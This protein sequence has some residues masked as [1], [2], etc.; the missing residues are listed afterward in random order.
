M[1]IKYLPNPAMFL[2]D[3][4]LLFEINRRVLH[5]F[6]IALA[7]ECPVSDEEKALA[8]KSDH[9]GFSLWD[10]QDDPEGID[11]APEGFEEGVAKLA[12][13]TEKARPRFETRRKALGF[14]I[15]GCSPDETAQRAYKA[16]GDSTG[17]VNFL[18]KP[19]PKWAELPAA[20][21][22]AWRDATAAVV[23]P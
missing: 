14:V 22:K 6:G 15:Q 10:N 21:Q 18:G 23:E 4:G 9:G 16:Y 8:A 2:V 20:I 11:F 12:T 7:V 19:M 1:T 13:T 17:W 5:P 3:S